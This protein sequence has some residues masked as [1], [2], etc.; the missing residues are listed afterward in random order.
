MKIIVTG[1]RDNEDK[2][3][4]FEKLDAIHKATPIT[5]VVV[6]DCPTGTDCFAW[7]WAKQNK[8]KCSVYSA[9]WKRIGK[10]A[11]PMRNA[12]MIDHNLNAIFVVAFPG[13]KGTAHCVD[14]ALSKNL[15]I[16]Q[17]KQTTS[18]GEKT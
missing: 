16:C 10:M 13:G 7:L 1:G 9:D 6:G 5:E 8:I 14:Y 12:T 15:T 4:H 11:G 3:F 2:D 18:K 17:P